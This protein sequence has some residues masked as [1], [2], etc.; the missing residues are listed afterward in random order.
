MY[1][2][3]LEFFTDS[4]DTLVKVRACGLSGKVIKIFLKTS[5]VIG[6]TTF[7][8]VMLINLNFHL[9]IIIPTEYNCTDL[10]PSNVL[11]CMLNFVFYLWLSYSANIYVK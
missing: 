11:H 9:R 1:E 8:N 2:I 4:S 3:D 10:S 6:K 7:E 5:F